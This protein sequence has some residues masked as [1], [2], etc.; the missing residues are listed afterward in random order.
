[1][2]RTSEEIYENHKDSILKG[3]LPRLFADYADDAILLT[4]DGT[5]VGKDAIQSW[6]QGIF[7]S[8]PNTKFNFEKVV[9]EGDTVLLQW[10]GESDLATF[11]HGVA[12]FIIREG[13]IKR[14]TEWFIIIPKET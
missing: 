9:V 6:F 1:M 13:M 8:H 3:D 7:E 11:P 4:M 5:Y 10:S 14:Q 12:T 2:T